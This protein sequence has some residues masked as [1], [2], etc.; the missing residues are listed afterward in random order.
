MPS[1]IYTGFVEHTRLRPVYHRLR[2]PLYVY[3]LDLDELESL[4]RKLPLFGYNRRRPASIHDRDYLDYGGG[5]IKDKLLSRLSAEGFTSPVHRVVLITS[6]RYFNHVFNPVSFYYCLD[7][8]G[9]LPAVAAEVNNTFGERHVYIPVPEQEPDVRGFSRFVA[10]KAFFVSPFNTLEGSYEFFF[11]PLYPELDIRIH[12]I[13]NGEVAFKARLFGAPRP[14]T[15]LVHAKTILRHPFTPHLTIL[16]ILF[17]AAKLRLGKK[18][19]FQEKPRPGHRLTIRPYPDRLVKGLPENVGLAGDRLYP[20]PPSP[21]CISSKAGEGRHYEPPLSYNADEEAA[22]E[23]ILDILYS[24][25]GITP[26]TI[27]P[28]Y[29]HAV[30][31][32]RIFRF[33][34]DLEFLVDPKG[35]QIHFRSASRVGYSD[36]GA[37]RRRIL[38]IRKRFQAQDR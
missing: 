25:P 17:E 13:R 38:R 34:D 30:C 16:R 3:A 5:R 22:K 33:K 28:R 26:V 21:N 15:P 37:N 8:E 2:Y 27:K 1:R 11:S 32:S 6:A 19:P 24:E 14:L 4:D 9:G 12:L 29:I 18:L 7:A 10:D 23:R 20:R 36:L 35:R 31:E